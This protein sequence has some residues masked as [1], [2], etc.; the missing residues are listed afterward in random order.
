MNKAP[1]KQHFSSGL[2]DLRYKPQNIT[3]HTIATS[4]SLHDFLIKC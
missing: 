1:F 4:I 3:G 2:L